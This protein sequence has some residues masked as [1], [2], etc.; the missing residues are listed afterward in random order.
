MNQ[1]NLDYA[2]HKETEEQDVDTKSSIIPIDLGLYI[3][4]A[5][6]YTWLSGLLIVLAGFSFDVVLI[7]ST[8][9]PL[10]GAVLVTL[11]SSGMKGV[12]DLFRG[13]FQWRFHPVWYVLAMLVPLA[14]FAARYW[15]GIFVVGAEAP[16]TW[17]DVTYFTAIVG[18][19]F[20]IWNGIG[21]EM[22]WRAFAL[23]RLQ[24][25]LG[26]L[27]GTVVLGVIWAFWHTPLFFIPGS[28]QYGQSMFEYAVWVVCLS[29]II[30]AIWNKSKQSVLVAIIVHE[31]QN[32]IAFSMT[33]PDGTGYYFL[34]LWLLF[35]LVF[36]AILPRPLV[37]ME[38]SPEMSLETCPSCRARLRFD[39]EELQTGRI[40]CQNCGESID[41]PKAVLNQDHS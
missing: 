39:D 9:G 5:Y 12:R 35:A 19:V 38:V 20:L 30:T 16:A 27:G 13:A 40:T 31:T 29:I 4:I 26:S 18:P 15:I 33:S 24:Q 23:P 8:P 37:K 11:R 14:V 2:P 22:G 32:T 1:S 34:A 7:L 41:V 28:K 17:I 25:H 21:E 10:L 3:V 6:G 36:I